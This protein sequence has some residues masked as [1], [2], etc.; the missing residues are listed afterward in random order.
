MILLSKNKVNDLLSGKD[1]STEWT[2]GCLWTVGQVELNVQI[3]RLKNQYIFNVKVSIDLGSLLGLSLR[4]WV[5][6]AL[7]GAEGEPT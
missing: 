5:D 3:A 4:T 6:A 2:L 1:G 7:T